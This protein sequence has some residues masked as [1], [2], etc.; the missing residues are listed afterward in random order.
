MYGSFGGERTIYNCNGEKI[1]T[2]VESGEDELAVEY[3]LGRWGANEMIQ[4]ARNWDEGTDINYLENEMGSM[5]GE[6]SNWATESALETKC[7]GVTDGYDFSRVQMAGTER[8]GGKEGETERYE[9]TTASQA[10]HEA[11]RP[12]SQ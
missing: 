8:Y 4:S 2:G 6:H 1:A 11:T 12:S 5:N 10:V 9:G 7:R 3:Y